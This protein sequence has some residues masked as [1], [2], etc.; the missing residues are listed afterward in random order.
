MKFYVV[1]QTERQEAF[2]KEVEGKAEKAK[3]VRQVR[4]EG[5]Y[6]APF[7]IPAYA[8]YSKRQLSFSA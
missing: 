5:G 3:L 7:L 1:I 6:A 8:E 4:K 2:I